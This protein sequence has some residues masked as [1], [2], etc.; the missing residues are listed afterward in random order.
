[1]LSSENYLLTCETKV[2]GGL[3]HETGKRSNMDK[4]ITV[5]KRQ[6]KGLGDF[7]NVVCL[8]PTAYHKRAVFLALPTIALLH[9]S[10]SFG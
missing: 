1:M 4:K 10:I 5:K 3:V 8:S 9:G 7:R 2:S 6:G